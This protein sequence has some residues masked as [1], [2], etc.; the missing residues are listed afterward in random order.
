MPAAKLAKVSAPFVLCTLP[1]DRAQALPCDKDR[2]VS[3]ARMSF[4]VCRSV[5]VPVAAKLT[6]GCYEPD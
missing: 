4:A 3:V 2:H 5:M 1:L 6:R